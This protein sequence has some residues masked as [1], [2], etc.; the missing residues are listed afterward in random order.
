[1]PGCYGAAV[2]PRGRLLAARQRAGAFA[3]EALLEG[4]SRGARLHPEMQRALGDVEVEHDLRYREGGDE[5]H[6]LDVYR[7]KGATGKLPVVLHVHGGGFRIL[8]K[9]THWMMGLGFARPRPEGGGLLV[10]NV[11]YRLAP[12]HPFPAALEDVCAAWAWTLD[13]VADFGGDPERIALAGESAG[14]NLVT[15]LTV[16]T[17]FRRGEPFARATFDRGAVPRAAMPFCGLLQVSDIA[18]FTAGTESVLVRDR[19]QA[20]SQGYLG[21]ASGAEAALADPLVLLEGSDLPER[22]LPPFFAACGGADPIV[23]D[24]RRLADALRRRGVPVDAPEYAG[25]PHAFHALLW[26]T[27]AQRCWDDALCW[28]RG[29]LADE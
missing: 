29:V 14:A 16:A 25:E 24:T 6:R 1:M 13:R 12:K 2:F 8:S 10:V 23:D 9:D 19:M 28:V 11:N 20:V 15:A 22:S 17:C 26:R 21:R 3:V 5:A 18:R 7:P 4:L 27:Q